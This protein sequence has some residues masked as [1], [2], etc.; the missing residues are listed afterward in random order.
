MKIITKYIIFFIIL[1][2]LF[3][4]IYSQASTETN[5]PDRIV[6][7]F[8]VKAFIKP[9]KITRAPVYKIRKIGRSPIANKI[10]KY[11]YKLWQYLNKGSKLAIGPFDNFYDA[12]YAIGMYNLARATNESMQNELDNFVD[13]SKRDIVYWFSLKFDI[14]KRTRAFKL[15]RTAARVASGSV[16][17]FREALWEFLSFQ[18]LAVGPFSSQIEAEEAKR[19]YRLE[20]R[21]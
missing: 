16:K 20:E 21:K 8:Y 15:K 12:K 17:Q 5:N 3:V 6:Y 1:N 2:F 13:T 11:E 9:D 14:S 10:S 18:Q 7:W 19:L 4:N